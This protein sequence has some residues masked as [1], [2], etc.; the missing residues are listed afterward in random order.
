MKGWLILALLLFSGAAQAQV[1]ED[2][3]Y[4]SNIGNVSFFKQN[5]QQSMPVIHLNSD[6]QLELYFDDMV[7][8]PKNY[9]YTFVLC[10]ANWTPADV[11][12]FD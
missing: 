12:I 8:Y 5:N 7:G 3:I 9:Y 1:Y 4:M 6:E 11:S 10:N 2:S